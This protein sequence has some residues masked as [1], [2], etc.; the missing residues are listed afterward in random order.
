MEI[1]ED[2]VPQTIRTFEYVNIPPANLQT[3]DRRDPGNVRESRESGQRSAQARVRAVSRHVS[4]HAGRQH[5]LAVG[6]DEFPAADHRPGRPG[7]RHHAADVSR[8]HQLHAAHRL[9]WKRSSTRSTASAIRSSTIPKNSRWRTASRAQEWPQ[10]R[11][12]RRAKLSIDAMETLVRH[13]DG[14][15]EERKAIITVSEGWPMFRDGSAV[16]DGR[17]IA[18]Q[19]RADRPR[20]HHRTGRPAGDVRS[21]ECDWRLP[22]PRSVRQHPHADR[23]D[24]GRRSSSA[25]C[26]TSRIAR[27]PAST[28]SI[29]AVSRRSTRRSAPTAPPPVVVDQANL[30]NKLMGLRELAE[31]TDGLAGENTSTT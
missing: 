21:G 19:A 15:R 29:R 11:D 12:R 27:T 28:P 23:R 17:K 7:R 18:Q 16:D 2:N 31:R 6:A 4:H 20:H 13:L 1:R 22:E 9:R 5:E 8:R 24:G 3:G 30:R 26:P 14:L 25:I 10:F